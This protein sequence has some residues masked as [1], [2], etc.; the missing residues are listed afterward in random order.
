[1]I[2]T[3][4]EMMKRSAVYMLGELKTIQSL[5]IL[6][7]VLFEQPEYE[8]KLQAIHAMEKIMDI[9]VIDILTKYLKE[10]TDNNQFGDL[11]LEVIR[12]LAKLGGEK[13]KE[14]F[15]DLLQYKS[16]P[17]YLREEIEFQ[18]NLLERGGK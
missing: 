5:P 18:L 8:V 15:Q 10:S 17:V 14:V 13:V 2:Q 16:L 4:T 3:G 1:M 9:Q 7:E 6:E 11:K 12:V